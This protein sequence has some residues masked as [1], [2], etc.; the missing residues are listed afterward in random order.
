[1]V[2]KLEKSIMGVGQQ[3]ALNP[4]VTARKSDIFAVKPA[5]RKIDSSAAVK[6]APRTPPPAKAS[7]PGGLKLPTAPYPPDFPHHGGPKN[8]KKSSTHSGK[9]LPM[10]AAACDASTPHAASS[11]AMTNDSTGGAA[12]RTTI[13]TD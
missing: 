10:A 6:P 4:P 5:A 12:N 2:Q 8:A 9:T 3:Q 1:M 7:V 13:S 11:G